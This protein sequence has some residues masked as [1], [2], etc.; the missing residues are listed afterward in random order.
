MN[1]SPLRLS[2]AQPD[3]EARFAQRLHWSSETDH[4]FEQ[5]VGDILGLGE[6]AAP[7]SRSKGE[8]VAA[9]HRDDAATQRSASRTAQAT[10]RSG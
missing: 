5:R 1:A 8:A 4:A 2:T 6:D 7:R 9:G 10:R 3:F